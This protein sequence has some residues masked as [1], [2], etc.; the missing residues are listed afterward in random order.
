MIYKILKMKILFFLIIISNNFSS[1]IIVKWEISVKDQQAKVQ[2]YN[3]SDKKTLFPLDTKSFQAH[4]SDN[5]IISQSNWNKDYPF[6]SF[7]VN[8]FNK[9]T[10]KRLETNSDIPYLDLSD[11][12]K[13]KLNIESI[14]KDY[15]SKINVWKEKNGLKSD[16]DAQINYYL[17]KNLVYLKPKEKKNFTIPLNLRNITNKDNAIHDSY[18]LEK[19]KN[20]TIFL[21]LQ[22]K[23]DIY[24]YLTNAQKQKL[25]EYKLFTGSLESNKIE[26]KL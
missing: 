7:T 15:N 23:D 12:E 24:N 17:I 9:L 4:F 19:N 20:Y 2:I 14:N 6:F 11:F 22:V 8:A 18:L 16:L 1:Q 5:Y 3:N 21:S 10:Q 25:K 26:I 13:Q